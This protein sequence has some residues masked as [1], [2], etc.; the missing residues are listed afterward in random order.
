M[1]SKLIIIPV[2]IFILAIT[3]VS[4]FTSIESSVVK[5]NPDESRK[6]PSGHVPG[7]YLGLSQEEN[8]ELLRRFVDNI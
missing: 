7:S 6:Y 2:L 1:D 3:S 4:K 8:N 5:C